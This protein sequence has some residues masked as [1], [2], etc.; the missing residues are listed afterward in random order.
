MEDEM[1]NKV[2]RVLLEST[3][4]F[5]KAMVRGKGK[6]PSVVMMMADKDKLFETVGK[7]PHGHN[8][9]FDDLEK[10]FGVRPKDLPYPVLAP[11]PP[12]VSNWGDFLRMALNDTKSLMYAV[13]SEAFGAKLEVYREAKG[14]FFNI[15]P[16][17]L[18]DYSLIQ[19]GC[20]GKD[21]MSYA[22]PINLNIIDRDGNL[23]RKVGDFKHYLYKDVTLPTDW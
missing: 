4:T 17:N 21:L 5:S 19:M 2:G 9:F 20:K 6:Q 12:K 22:A 10:E 23:G 18:Q 11:L 3:M 1:M 13:M 7:E 16:D 8:D 14:E 15:H